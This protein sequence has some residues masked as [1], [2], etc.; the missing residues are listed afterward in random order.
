[1]RGDTLS[2]AELSA[3]VGQPLTSILVEVVCLEMAGRATRTPGGLYR[4]LGAG[5]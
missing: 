2:A 4:R 5:E 3:R 1:L